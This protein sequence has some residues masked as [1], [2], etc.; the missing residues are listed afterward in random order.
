MDIFLI[1]AIIGFVVGLIV[2]VAAERIN[3]KPPQ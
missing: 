3:N 1:S 2:C